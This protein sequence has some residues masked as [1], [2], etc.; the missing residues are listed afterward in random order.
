MAVPC[1]RVGVAT[2]MVQ[3]YVVK[4]APDTPPTVLLAFAGSQGILG[5][6]AYA[7][8]QVPVFDELYLVLTLDK[9]YKI[10]NRRASILKSFHALPTSPTVE[11]VRPLTR[12]LQRRFGF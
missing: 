12:R 10:Q 1:E 4:A 7:V 9:P 8:V 2:E 6:G 11:W 5:A 3:T